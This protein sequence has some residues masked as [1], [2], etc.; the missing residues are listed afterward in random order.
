MLVSSAPTP[1][2]TGLSNP[3][4]IA[5]SSQSADGTIIYTVPAGKKFIGNVYASSYYSVRVTPSGGSS[6]AIN[7]PSNFSIP[8]TLLAGTVVSSFGTTA[9]INLIGVESD[10]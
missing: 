10:L 3:R 4:Q 2:T 8:I 6:A 1:S 5:T 9:A 7:V